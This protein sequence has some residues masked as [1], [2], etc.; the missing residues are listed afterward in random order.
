MRQEESDALD[1][2]FQ[3]KLVELFDGFFRAR[4]RAG[5]QE[6][7]DAETVRFAKG[8]KLARETLMIAQGVLGK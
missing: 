2:A 6:A 4:L 3:D 7:I 1:K 5:T 8:V